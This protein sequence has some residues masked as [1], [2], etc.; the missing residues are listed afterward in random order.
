MSTQLIKSPEKITFILIK[1]N[2]IKNIIFKKENYPKIY[3]F[4]FLI[5]LNIASY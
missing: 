2:L 3:Y 5:Y 4:V 1:N